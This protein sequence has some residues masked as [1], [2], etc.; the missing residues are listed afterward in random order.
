MRARVAVSMAVLKAVEEVA[1]VSPAVPAVRSHALCRIVVRPA[2]S[3]FGTNRIW[4]A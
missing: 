2:N 3:P 1:E 4:N